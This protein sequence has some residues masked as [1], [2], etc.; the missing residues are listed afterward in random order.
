MN[1]DFYIRSAKS[2]D[3]IP[4]QELR[5]L[6]WQDNYVNP[7]TGVT[8]ELLVT[9]LASLPVLQS[10]VDY[11]ISMLQKAGN[12]DKN[13]VATYGEKIV[14]VVFYDELSNGNGDIGVFVDRKYRAQGIGTALLKELVNK[15]TNTLEVTIFAKNK[16]RSLYEK[17]GFKVEGPEEK[18]FFDEKIYLPSQRLVLQR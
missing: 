13:L 2:E 8:K 18:H 4:V 17:F 16:S 15:T 3:V 5:K 6:G 11:F 14:G 12:K 10:D 7:E 1:T 9:K